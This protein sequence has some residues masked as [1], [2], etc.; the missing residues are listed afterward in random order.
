MAEPI[1]QVGGDGTREQLVASKLSEMFNWDFF[2]TPR[3]YFID[4]LVNINHANGYANYIGGLEVKWLNRPTNSEVKFPYQKLQQIWLTEPA[5]DR[6]D[7]YNR[8]VI[9]YTDGLLV[10]PAY[11]LRCLDPI[12]GLTRADT[13]E[14]D[15]NVHFNATK[16]FPQYL[17]PV[18]INE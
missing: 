1:R 15:F 17:L 8:I 11:A 9:R 5:T 7:A 14:H 6:P 16:D 4:F 2:P 3:Y 13:N 10:M 18:V 12:Y